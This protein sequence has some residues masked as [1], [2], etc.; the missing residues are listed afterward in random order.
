[1]LEV[2]TSSTFVRVLQFDQG[3]AGRSTLAQKLEAPMEL[4]VNVNTLDGATGDW[5]QGEARRTRASVE[6]LVA[7]TMPVY[8]IQVSLQ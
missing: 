2:F 4:I 3:V 7:R 5:I 6:E 8:N 1:M